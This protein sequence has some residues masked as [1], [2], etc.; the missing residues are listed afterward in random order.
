MFSLDGKVAVVTGGGRGIGQSCCLA[1]AEQGAHV[2][3]LDRGAETAAQVEAMMETQGW[4][5]K[6]YCVDITDREA[7]IKTASQ[8]IADFGRIDIWV[9]NA[10]WDKVEPFLKNAPQTWERIININLKGTTRASITVYTLE[11]GIYYDRE[12]QG[13]DSGDPRQRRDQYARH[14]H[15][16]VHCQPRGLL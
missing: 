16:A 9:N 8:I 1:L 10:G 2:A 7:V 6:S 12:N 5:A 15:G 3:V 13:A 4:K 11:G 14:P